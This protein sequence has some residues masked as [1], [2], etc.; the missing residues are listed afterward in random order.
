[1]TEVPRRYGPSPASDDR[2]I[3]SRR[4]FSASRDM[5]FRAFADPA[6]LAGWWG[7]AG[8]VNAFHEF[9]FRIGGRWCFTMR[10]PDG[11]EYPMEKVFAEVAAPERIVM[12]HE[13]P[14]HGH[15][16]TMTYAA[17]E[18]ERTELT[19]RM[20]FDTV[21]EADRVREFVVA[22]NE[23]NFDRL[24]AMLASEAPDA[25]FTSR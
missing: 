12:R 4:V 1:M 6:R 11:A 20:R 2:E 21:E 13:D 3:V 10:A 17:L 18:P 5:L 22:A 19:W 25:H 23:Q 15:T 14:V 8:F 7:P 16:L 9:D 24:A